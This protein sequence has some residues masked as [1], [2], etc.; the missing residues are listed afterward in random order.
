[1]C[2]VLP[3]SLSPGPWLPR[4]AAA[5][6]IC[7]FMWGCKPPEQPMGR[8]GCA[9]PEIPLICAGIASCWGLYSSLR[10]AACSSRT[11][12]SLESQNPRMLRRKGPTRIAT[13]KLPSPHSP[14]PP[15]FG[16]LWLTFFQDSEVHTELPGHISAVLYLHLELD[17]LSG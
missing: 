7:S 6:D 14:S 5:L 1:M 13:L 11:H 8:H 9:A 2:P 3:P 4:E 16:R 12:Q 10:A 15:P 17:V